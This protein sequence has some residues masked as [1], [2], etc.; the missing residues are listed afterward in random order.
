M[1]TFL[2]IF[3]SPFS[4]S[5]TIP[6]CPLRN[7]TFS[8]TQ[9][10]NF[11]AKNAHTAPS[12]R[13]AANTATPPSPPLYAC[14]TRC[15]PPLHH[16][17]YIVFRCKHYFGAMGLMGW[18]G[19]VLGCCCCCC[20]DCFRTACC[21]LEAFG[22]FGMGIERTARRCFCFGAALCSMSLA[23][24]AIALAIKRNT[25]K[26]TAARS[27]LVICL[28]KFSARC[29]SANALTAPPPYVQNQHPKSVST[30]LQETASQNF[31]LQNPFQATPIRSATRH[32]AS[33]CSFSAVAHFSCST[34]KRSAQALCRASLLRSNFAL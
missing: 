2:A 13:V 19:C 22:D 34:A 3:G 26:R 29:T 24:S 6:V 14:Y 25:S 31:S 32:F 8:T 5:I 27:S 9:N 16:S 15:T 17:P 28:I 4:T 10:A 18:I 30:S 33:A 11:H 20:E 23:S 21:N 7:C 12:Q 1:S